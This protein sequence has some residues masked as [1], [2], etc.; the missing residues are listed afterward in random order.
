ML[1]HEGT[2]KVVGDE[3]ND[4]EEKETLRTLGIDGMLV[5]R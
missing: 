4:V 5:V 1:V 2:R 3:E